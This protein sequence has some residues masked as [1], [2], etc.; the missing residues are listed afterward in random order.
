MNIWATED[1]GIKF[2]QT[3]AEISKGIFVKR[4]FDF[5]NTCL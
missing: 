1:L 4:I 5:I 3:D 2:M